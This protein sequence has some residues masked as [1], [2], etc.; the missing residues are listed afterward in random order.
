MSNEHL[1][2]IYL[3]ESCNVL[4]NCNTSLIKKL[5]GI[6]LRDS[7]PNGSSECFSEIANP[8]EDT[9]INYYINKLLINT[10]I[11]SLT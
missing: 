6:P 7:S 11:V 10:L 9:P 8:L 5:K 4:S 1:S 2:T 3:M